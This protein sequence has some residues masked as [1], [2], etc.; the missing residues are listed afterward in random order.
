M[1]QEP[2]GDLEGFLMR[3]DPSTLV[4]VLVELAGDHPV[5]QQR[6]ARMQL[7]DRPGRLAAGFRKTLSA[8]R[9]SP[10]FYGYRESPEFGRS[11]E[12]WLDQVE[13][14]LLPKDP[15]AA[16]ALFEAFIEADASWFERADDSDGCIG[17][18]VRAACRHWLQA[19][20]RSG[21]AASEWPQ[22]LVRLVSADGYGARDELLRRADLL[23]DESELRG[24]VARFEA[25]MTEAL[26]GSRRSQGL[27]HEVYKASAALTLLAEALHDPDVEHLPEASR[28]GA[29][30]RARQLA[31]D[32]DDPARAAVL[33]LELGDAAAAEL[34]LVSEPASIRGED[35]SVL[36][37]L[38]EALRTHQ[39][40]RGETA[41]YRALLKGV[42]D[43]A[44][45]RAY[46][47][48]ARYWS[49][50]RQIGNTGTD[51]LPL[52]SNEDFEAEIRS[53]HVRKAAF[54][55]QVN[56]KRSAQVGA[57]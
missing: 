10:S 16:L 52:Q 38:A 12:A 39:C 31:L 45:A 9:R 53:R 54:W 49:R 35:Y 34:K 4:A 8:W 43:R 50:L 42:L 6:L 20:A 36:V 37:P 56:G 57:D 46:G 21:A 29:L 48:A 51:L 30:Q 26:A 15:A 32:H 18:A 23:L 41:V 17:E 11:L 14:E 7:A 27:P 3:Q 13:R 2:A 19:A 24:L 25:L 44:Q 33:L 47:H 28:P 40:S 5:V 55:A 1:P 22:R